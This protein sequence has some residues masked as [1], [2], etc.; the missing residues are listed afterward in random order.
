[1]DVFPTR[2]EDRTSQIRRLGNK[3]LGKISPYK[4]HLGIDLLIKLSEDQ[5]WLIQEQ[6]TQIKELQNQLADYEQELYQ[7]ENRSL[8]TNQANYAESSR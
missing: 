1:M 5:D 2:S 6:A 4:D 7:K 8:T 3:E